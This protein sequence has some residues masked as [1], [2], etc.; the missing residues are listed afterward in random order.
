MNF[1]RIIK[2]LPI[3]FW[4]AFGKDSKSDK[5]HRRAKRH[6]PN[7]PERAL[8]DFTKAA[9]EAKNLDKHFDILKEKIR[10]LEKLGQKKKW[11]DCLHSFLNTINQKIQIKGSK[12]DIS[13]FLK[14]AQ[15]HERLENIQEALSDYERIV[16]IKNVWNAT[17]L[18]I[19]V[20]NDAKNHIKKLQKK[21][22]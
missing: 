12:A 17:K 21:S 19:E 15:I 5:F 16:T 14:R 9:E 6:L 1:F 8:L 7:F 4:I 13:L 10:L 3:A 11:Q 22:I 2:L 18:E 20:I